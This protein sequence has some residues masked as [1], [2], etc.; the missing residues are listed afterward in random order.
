MTTVYAAKGTKLQATVSATLTDIPGL[1]DIKV[2]GFENDLIEELSLDDAYPTVLAAGTLTVG[3]LSGQLIWDPLNDVQQALHTAKNAGAVVVGN[4][5]WAATG[6]EE[7]CTY[8][9]NKF[10]RSSEAKGGLM[11]DIEVTFTAA[12]DLNEADPA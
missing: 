5:I 1:K 12:I 9:V 2:T 7:A 8:I 10:E 3:K 4:L 11:A 6:V